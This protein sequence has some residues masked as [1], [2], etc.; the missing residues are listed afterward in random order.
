MAVVGA[1]LSGLMAANRLH[2]AGASTVVL[3]A[4]GEVGGRTKSRLCGGRIVDLGGEWVG[5][6]YLRLR[7]LVTGLGLHL[8][9]TPFLP[10]PRVRPEARP[11][12]EP[13]SLARLA[14]AVRRLGRSCRALP[15][16]APWDGDGVQPRC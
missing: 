9:P 12:L 6:N 10:R 7:R 8:E 14:V 13:T 2:E 1:G 11:P 4:T 15:A 5:R 16:E 3:E